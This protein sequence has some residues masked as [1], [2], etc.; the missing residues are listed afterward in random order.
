MSL[1][2]FFSIWFYI[3]IILILIGLVVS[4]VV[5]THES[6]LYILKLI[7]SLLQNIGIA[8]FV[9]NI[10]TF[11]IGTE[12]FLT[13]VRERLVNIIISK[14]FIARLSSEEQRK[15]LHIVLKPAKELSNVY[16]GI[17]DYFN[18]YINDSMSLFDK[19][20]RGHMILDA[21]ASYN[22]DRNCIQ[23]EFDI[24]YI[25]Y[26]IGDKFE[27]ILLGLEDGRSKHIKTI[28]RGSGDI[29]EVLTDK[30]AESIENK[31][32]TM[33][34]MWEIKVPEKFNNLS[35]INVSRRII[36]Y[37]EDHWQVFSYKTIKACDQLTIILRCEDGLVIKKCS[38]YGVQNRY[39]IDQ[40]DSRIKVTYGNWLS[41]GF[42][43]NLMVSKQGFHGKSN[44]NISD[45]LGV[46]P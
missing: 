27:P 31:D 23:V 38:T 12:E 19:C 44:K 40:E 15:L 1:K 35:Q 13:L 45:E 20:Y 25:V 33:S 3:S 43:V 30:N 8:I 22:E 39:S 18:Q 29:E 28:I 26:K 37:G 32:S 16:S 42:G 21:V 7:S 9:A 5:S 34:Q 10:F 14:D 6:H 17:N 2:K 4:D 11:I 46:S 36:E 24:D 41:P